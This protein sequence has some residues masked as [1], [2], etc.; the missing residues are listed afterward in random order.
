MSKIK[1][2]VC[3]YNMQEMFSLG[4]LYLSN[5]I[6]A[7]AKSEDYPKSDLTIMACPECGTGRL[8]EVIDPNI[9]YK[10][11]WYYSGVNQTMRDYLKDVV[12]SCI[13]SIN[14]EQG[15]IWLDI[16]SNDGTLLSQVPDFF[17]KIGIDPADDEIQRRARQHATIVNDYFSKEAF[18]KVSYR[19]AIGKAKIVTCIAMFYDLADPHQFLDDVYEILDDKGLFVIQ[20][21][22]TPLMFHQL[23]FGN[24]CAEHVMYYSLVGLERLLESRGF[25]VCDCELNDVNGGSFRV[26]CTKSPHGYF[27]FRSPQK[28]DV[29][30]FRM[31]SLRKHEKETT[32]LRSYMEF[33]DRIDDLKI[34]TVKF[35]QQEVNRGKTVYGYGASTKGNTLLQY[36]GL[37]NKLITKIAERNPA[38]H[39]LKTIGSEIPICSEQEMRNDHPDYLLI[40]P[41]HFI[42]EF[43]ER[44]IA[45]L[46]AG[47]KFITPSPRFEVI[48]YD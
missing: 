32:S 8:K 39:G 17:T 46:K 14:C 45:Y 21:S 6:P 1:C 9:L 29:A 41:W 42:E 20:I 36:F 33:G 11:Y 31:E 22:Y 47:G 2:T 7:D 23:E 24:I 27:N 15:D 5:F 44:E 37:D 40:L 16:A 3:G 26:Y 34:E 10:K 48:G 12:D 18:R 38:K 35:I 4:E 30:H 28:R 13:S 19:H 25:I 43:K